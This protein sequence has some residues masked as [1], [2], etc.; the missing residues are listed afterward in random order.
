MVTPQLYCIQIIKSF[1]TTA[2]Q[3]NSNRKFRYVCIWWDVHSIPLSLT[4]YR[5]SVSSAG[6]LLT[7]LE[8][9]SCG[10]D[11]PARLRYQ[12]TTPLTFPHD[13]WDPLSFTERLWG[14]RFSCTQSR[15][16]KDRSN[17]K[18]MN[19]ITFANHNL[20]RDTKEPCWDWQTVYFVSNK[21]ANAVS[22]SMNVKCKFRFWYG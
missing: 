6:P 19:T 11:P 5:T 16:L 1:C 8:E 3:H 7:V 2:Q 9:C 21:C 4:S 10:L 15:R 20:L 13:I 12:S 22:Y 14:E 17:Q 18:I